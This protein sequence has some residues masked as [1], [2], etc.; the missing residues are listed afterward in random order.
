[1]GRELLESKD[2]KIIL[3]TMVLALIGLAL[4]RAESAFQNSENIRTQKAIE[5][6]L[7]RHQ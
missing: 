6:M 3:I 4:L 7:N 5:E 2:V 1:M